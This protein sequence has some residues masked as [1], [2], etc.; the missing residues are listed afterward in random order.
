MNQPIALSLAIR[1][2][3]CSPLYQSIPL[4][5]YGSNSW[6]NPQATVGLIVRE[7]V[8]LRHI[9]NKKG[10]DYGKDKDQRRGISLPQKSHST[11]ARVEKRD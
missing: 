7:Y 2:I 8:A 6:N 10:D 4:K 11:Q 3:F 9:N 5:N 1:K